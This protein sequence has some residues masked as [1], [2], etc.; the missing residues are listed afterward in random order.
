MSPVRNTRGRALLA[1]TA[2][3][4][5]AVGFAASLGHGAKSAACIPIVALAVAA[6]AVQ[7]AALGA[8]LLARALWWSNLALG[9]LL[10]VTGGSSE[11]VLG[12]SLTVGCAAALALADRRALAA[13][14]ETAGFRPVA[15]AGTLQLLMVLALA[16]AQTL[17]LFAA[18]GAHRSGPEESPALLMLGA[19]AF[20]VAFAGLYRLALWGVVVSMSA[21]LA[22]LV[23]LATGA[24][25]P[26]GDVVA[27]LYALAL[28]QLAA[29]VPMIVSM[30]T[31]KPLPALPPRARS[32]A[33]TGVVV[34]VALASVLA[35]FYR[36][37]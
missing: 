36:A 12:V 26:H 4:L 19:A 5:G 17:G 25:H 27:L 24:L 30:V 35:A 11:F 34:A 13:A 16:D 32:A 1:S 23:T 15:Y 7:V 8:Q 14:A 3:V 37:R 22:L 6:V 9:A 29:P 33:A 21:A 10:C 28:L 2:S 20:L 31:R 18:I